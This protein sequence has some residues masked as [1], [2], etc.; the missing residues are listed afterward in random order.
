MSIL[1][2]NTKALI[3]ALSVSV[4]HT[5][6]HVLQFEHLDYITTLHF[7]FNVMVQKYCSKGSSINLNRGKTVT[8]TV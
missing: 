4:N 5:N 6:A 7:F 8:H 1:L 2:S 3:T